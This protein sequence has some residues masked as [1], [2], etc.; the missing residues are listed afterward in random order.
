VGISRIEA[1]CQFECSVCGYQFSVRSGT[2]FH[3]SNLP[4]S[5]WFR[6]IGA[7]DRRPDISANEL[8]QLLGVSYK[9]AWNLRR[10]IRAAM[11]AQVPEVRAILDNPDC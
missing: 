1:R 10:R 7:I 4:L 3:G 9:T 2:V 5:K 11:S 6:A 8:G